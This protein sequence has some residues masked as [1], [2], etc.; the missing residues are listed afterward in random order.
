MNEEEFYVRFSKQYLYDKHENQYLDC[1]SVVAIVGHSHPRIVACAHHQFG[2][3]CTAPGF[4]NKWTSLYSKKLVQLFPDSLEVS[5]L[6]I[7]DAEANDLA[8]R[9]SSQITFSK[10]I[11]AFA[12]TFVELHQLPATVRHAFVVA[13]SADGTEDASKVELQETSGGKRGQGKKNPISAKDSSVPG[14]LWTIHFLPKPEISVSE[15]QF[16]VNWVLRRMVPLDCV[17][18]AVE[19]LK[20]EG[21]HFSCFL[22]EPFLFMDEVGFLQFPQ[23]L[24]KT[25]TSSLLKDTKCLTIVDE[26]RTGLG[27]LG[28]GMWAFTDIGILPDLVVVGVILGNGFPLSAVLTSRQIAAAVPKYYSTFGGNP[29]SCRI[30]CAVFDVIDHEDI[31]KSA[32]AVGETLEKNLDAVATKFPDYMHSFFG[33]GLLFCLRFH[34]G[35]A[36]SPLAVEV[37]KRLFEEYKIDVFQKHDNVLV[38][39]PPL[40]FTVRNAEYVVQSL[41]SILTSISQDKCMS[42]G[43]PKRKGKLDQDS[44]PGT[45]LNK[46]IEGN[47]NICGIKNV[48]NGGRLDLLTSQYW[49]TDY[50][51]IPKNCRTV[52]VQHMP[53]KWNSNLAFSQLVFEDDI[54]SIRHPQDACIPPQSRSTIPFVTVFVPSAPLNVLRRNSIRGTWGSFGRRSDIRVFFVIGLVSNDSVLDNVIEQESQIFRDVLRPEV[55]DTYS[56]LT[57]KVVAAFEWAGN[58]SVSEFYLKADDDMFINIPGLVDFFLA[59]RKLKNVIFGRLLT[60]LHPV[61]NKESKWYVHWRE[62]RGNKFPNFVT[63]PAYAFTSDVLPKLVAMARATPYLKLEDVYVTGVLADR[64]GIERRNERKFASLLF[65]VRGLDV[66]DDLDIEPNDASEIEENEEE[67]FEVEASPT[68][69]SLDVETSILFVKPSMT[70][71]DPIELPAGKSVE[72]LVGF[73]NKGDKVLSLAVLD[74]SLRYPMDYNYFMQNFSS[75]TLHDYDVAPGEQGSILYEFVPAEAFGSRSFGLAIGLL[76]HDQ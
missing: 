59:R 19:N 20:K 13:N 31:I 66:E 42:N 63:G 14:L 43:S 35:N 6:C 25:I 40:C 24:L 57:R 39:Q 73:H 10:N 69:G 15:N 76:Y 34:P 64:A 23:G 74:G 32:K 38:L 36:E 61:R 41:N 55:V 27:R 8:I 50:L 16:H 22:I 46:T 12:G 72:V 67:E 7:N 17:L 29:L 65:Y 49:P 68:R 11:L 70:V 3:I 26:S 54:T 30:G 58:C 47:W 60:R 62:F 33:R 44:N 56:N 52:Q 1:S 4:L 71:D 21:I 48:D 2:Q 9:L 37:N 5:Y 45:S 18:Q 28:T 53:L 75:L 51:R